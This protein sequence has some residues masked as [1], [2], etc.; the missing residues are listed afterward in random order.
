MNKYT[1]KKDDRT[2]K[3]VDF[4]NLLEEYDYIIK[5][6][7][8]YLYQYNIQKVD[9]KN[10]FFGKYTL[11]ETLN[12]MK[13]GFQDETDYFLDTIVKINRTTDINNGLFMNYEGF[14]Y[15]MGKVVSGEPECCLNIGLPNSTPYI[16]IYVDISFSCIYK[17]E[18]IYNRGIAITNLINTLLLNG[19]IVDLYFMEYNHQYDLDIMYTLKVDTTTLSISCIAYLCTPDYFRKMGFIL[20]DLI[21]NKQSE[22]G[23]DNSTVLPFMLENFKKNKIFFIGGSYTNEKFCKNLQNINVANNYLINM[24]NKFCKDNEISISL[25]NNQNIDKIEIL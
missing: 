20:I 15:D 23:R 1:L 14:A 17:A 21:R 2:I 4:N 16:K 5:N 8:N 22:D 10:D 12:G 9:L 11:S 19:V 13:Y 6:K 24:F 18:Q 3:C 7:D 25:F